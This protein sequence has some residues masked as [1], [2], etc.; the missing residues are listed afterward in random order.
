[1]LFRSATA[2]TKT[3]DGV[4]VV[5][6]NL[7][8]TIEFNSSSE[9]FLSSSGHPANV[10][11]SSSDDGESADVTSDQLVI[12]YIPQYKLK[13]TELFGG[14]DC[15]GNKLAFSTTQGRQVIVQRYFLKIDADTNKDSTEPNEPLSLFCDAGYYSVDAEPTEIT[16]YGG[17]DDG[18]IIMK[19]VDHFRVLYG[20]IDAEDKFRYASAEDYMALSDSPKPRI[21]SI[22]LGVL[23]RSTESVGNDRMFKDDQNYQILDQLVRVK[24][25]DTNTSKYVRQVITQTVALRN[26][27]GDR[28][29]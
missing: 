9:N 21:V 1:M 8:S 20:Y 24:D 15:E 29:Q 5:Y 23:A 14:Y 2:T 6:S 18:Q 12:Q 25:T 11:T 17:D 3:E 22:Q 13:D 26:S 27:F 10:E 19:R 16:N 4:D 7:P 28:G